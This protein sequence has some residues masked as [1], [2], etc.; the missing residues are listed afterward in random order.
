MRVV[1][2][3]LELT[4]PRS[5]HPLAEVGRL[6]EGALD[7]GEAPVRF[8]VAAS[9][10][11]RWHA[12]VDVAEDLP[13]ERA[14]MLPSV[15]DVRVR[16][17]EDAR[18]FTAVLVVPTGIGCEIGGHAGDAMPVAA[19][20]ASA[21]D[22]LVTHPNVVNG[23]DL[24]ELPSNALYVEGSVVSRL[25]AGTVGLRPVRSNRVLSVIDHHPVAKY[26]DA[27]VNSVS[28]ARMSLGLDAPDV[29]VLEPRVQVAGRYTSSGRAV[30]EVRGLEGLFEVLDERKGTYDA[31]ALSTQVEVPFSYHIDYYEAR[32][33]MVNP[34]GGAEAMLTHTLSSIYDV[35][36]AHAPMIEGK[37]VD[38]LSLGVVDPR[39]AAEA[40][41]MAFFVCVLKGLRRSP[42]LVRLEG[43]PPEGVLGAEQ[44]SVLVIPD[45]AVGLP[46]LAAL[47]QGIPVVAVRENANLLHND[48]T[49]LP[50][51]PGQLR[52]VDN[53]WEVVGVLAA[54]RAGIDPGIVRRPVAD[55]NE[56]LEV[57]HARAAAWD[58][59]VPAAAA[60]SAASGGGRTRAAS[61]ARSPAAA[62]RRT[63][64][65]GARTS[66]PWSKGR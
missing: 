12:E 10:K 52:I 46:T 33:S 6:V 13:P 19:L 63:Q 24:M 55:T 58:G 18:R 2:R 35:P 43:P 60:R 23:S 40:I 31:V 34:W 44:V 14:A 36:S 7:V 42:R 41:S 3:E 17:A 16:E 30:G 45:G 64:P 48:L 51:R 57:S 65:P 56:V 29:V 32:G 11:R 66:N 54:M 4:A 61:A 53:Y 49:L 21:C 47:E 28:A 50:W 38:E 62:T 27:A 25:L 1:E 39:M 22:T 20:V 5:D 8:A 9:D 26:Q 37:E 15:F 59:K